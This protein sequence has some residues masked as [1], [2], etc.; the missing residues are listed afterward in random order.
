MNAE[1]LL[2]A[3]A[4]RGCPSTAGELADVAI[5]LAMA[6]GWPRWTWEGEPAKKAS[7]LLQ[8]MATKGDV[9]RAGVRRE[10]SRDVPLYGL[11]DR[12][13]DAHAPV[14]D[15]PD[16]DGTDHPFVGLTR[17][18]Q[19]AIFDALDT[20]AQIATRHRAE[21]RDLIARHD[22]ELA[23]HAARAKRDLLAAGLEDPR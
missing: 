19:F 16:P 15:A 13:Y 10:N 17:R 2:C 7:R 3:L 23:E 11:S 8:A 12:P 21:M 5:G 18:Q 6:S 20:S 22:R 14:P 1:L 4:R 9:V